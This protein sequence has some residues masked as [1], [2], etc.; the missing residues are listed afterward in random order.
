MGATR[1]ATCEAC[2]QTTMLPMIHFDEADDSALVDGLCPECED[3]YG[4]QIGAPVR[5]LSPDE[6]GDT[7]VQFI[8][9]EENAIRVRSFKTGATKVVGWTEFEKI[10]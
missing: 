10:G 6:N 5:L 8:Q 4:M 7:V 1:E 2:G 3:S 9:P